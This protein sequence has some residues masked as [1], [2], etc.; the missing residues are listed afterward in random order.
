M[1][2]GLPADHDVIA[3]YREQLDRLGYLIATDFELGVP[4]GAHLA[5]NFFT[6]QHLR[7]YDGDMPIDRLRARDV[8]RYQRFGD[9]IDLTEHDTVDLPDRDNPTRVRQ[10]D[11]TKVL[12]DEKFVALVTTLLNLVPEERRNSTGTFGINMFRTF[13]DVVTKPHH[14]DE[15]YVIVYVV[16]KT[17][18]GGRTQLLHK[19]RDEIVLEQ[20]LQPGQLIMFRDDIFRHGTSRL[21]TPTEMCAHRDA[22]ICTVDY[23]TNH[24]DCLD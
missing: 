1:T 4:F 20:E 17:A 13:T 10:F 19:Y 21:E 6:S 15:E 8:V 9:D 11:Q 22:L 14:D 24:R 2:Y 16:A 3:E 12:K 5:D 23:P 18:K 7:R